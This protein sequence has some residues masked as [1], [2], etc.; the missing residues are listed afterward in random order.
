[1]AQNAVL[2]SL[3]EREGL[4]MKQAAAKTAIPVLLLHLLERGYLPIPKALYPDLAKSYGVSEETFND[5]LGYP[6]P[7]EEEKTTNGK[8]AEL[9]SRALHWPVLISIYC[10]FALC[11]GLFGWGIAALNDAGYATQKAYDP[12]VIAL[13]SLVQSK[14]VEDPDSEKFSLAY[15][16]PDGS[17]LSI[18]APKDTRL[19]TT[20]VFIYTFPYESEVVTL[21]L[22]ANGD[23]SIF[24][25]V[26]ASEGTTLYQ[27]A[28]AI[29]E[30]HYLLQSLLDGEEASVEDAA[31]FQAKQELLTNYENKTAPVFARFAAANSFTIS[32]TP[33]QL[34]ASLARGNAALRNEIDLANNLLL[35]STL[36]GV[37]FLFAGVLLSAAK[38]IA[39]HQKK[40]YALAV[41]VP[42]LPERVVE[43]KPLPKNWKFQPFIPETAFRLAGVILALISSIVLFR[44][45]H[46]VLNAEDLSS[47]IAAGLSAMDFLKLMP[48]IPLATTLWFFIRIEVLHTTGNVIPAVILSFFLGLLYYAAENAFTL[49]F[50][51]NSDT[52]R[53]LLLSLFLSFMPGNLFW[54]MGCFSLLVLF[55]L[56]TPHFK[57]TSSVVVWRLLCVIPL[58]YLLVSLFYA[59]GTSLWGW[60]SW[61]EDWEGLLDKKELVSTSFAILYPFSIYLIRIFAVKRYGKE[62]ATLY[63]QGNRYFF[64][65]NILASVILGTLALASYFLQGSQVAGALG[66]KQSY[67]I[68]TLIP[69]ILFYHPHLGERNHILDLI[70]PCAYTVSLSFA[71]IY[72]ARFILFLV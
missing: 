19:A 65:K 32:L 30:D 22:S 49:Y 13:D 48:L 20:T 7:Q 58:A 23:S 43:K 16:D 27:G 8:L 33:N 57:K 45:A 4:S 28:G 12:S 46:A 21:T 41:E 15:L 63:F 26:E 68:A 34:I 60:A 54:G 38:I 62:N 18:S 39:H 53:S 55:L 9:K 59:I 5:P 11:L 14:G 17:G 67:W 64:L 25:F 51:L 44:I 31:V 29:S 37:I 52:Y 24:S 56:T 72:I 40:V 6:I 2:R 1:M 50:E 47:L 61:G 3:R 69:F 10:L 66:L 35:F 70:F 36:F 42:T 71:Y